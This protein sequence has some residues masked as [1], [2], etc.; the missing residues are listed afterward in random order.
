MELFESPLWK[1]WTQMRMFNGPLWCAWL[2]LFLAMLGLVLTLPVEGGRF[3]P[4]L[5][6]TMIGAG[7]LFYLRS[8][9][10]F[11]YSVQIQIVLLLIALVCAALSVH[12]ARWYGV[13]S[14]VGE[15]LMG[16]GMMLVFRSL[17][18]AVLTV[19]AL[20]AIHWIRNR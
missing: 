18:A 16:L 11:P 15:V 5:L 9:Q 7:A 10:N 3:T 17:F 2:G 20:L 6:G 13:A 8:I 4:R 19:L 12:E 1:A 14:A